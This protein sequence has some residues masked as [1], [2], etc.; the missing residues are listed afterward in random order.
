MTQDF[1]RLVITTDAAPRRELH[2]LPW[3]SGL[4]PTVTPLTLGRDD[5]APQADV[6]VVTW[7]V[8]EARALA[9]VLSPG[10][11]STAWQVYAHNWSVIGPTIRK[12]APAQESQRLAVMQTV[13]VGGV[14]VL[15]VKSE[16]HMS[17]DGTE[18]PVLALWKQ[19]IQ[20]VQPRLVLT[21]GTAGGIGSTIQL[22]DVVVSKV[23]QFDCKHDFKNAPFAQ[24]SYTSTQQIDTRMQGFLAYA[25]ASL[26]PANAVDL[27]A[28]DL[29]PTVLLHRDVLTTDFFAFDDAEDA[30]G[31]R[32]YNS[33]AAAVEM[34]DAVLGL[35]C[36]QIGPSAPSW[37]AVRNASD[38]QIADHPGDLAA[39]GNEAAHIYLE[40]GYWTTVCSALA[41]WAIIAATSTS[42]A[43]V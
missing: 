24:A 22:G 32:A 9:D 16:L 1:A 41:C 28:G 8:A 19:L 42:A 3:P 25:V 5:A 13:V 2:P 35:A 11:A 15:L 18:L 27:P 36:T 26:M 7:T 6:L 29:K 38:P 43:L 30:Y 34:G 21:T 23:V 10:V 33:L 39:Q 17:Q 37:L 4:I 14:K 31:L 20:E 40:Y 12:G